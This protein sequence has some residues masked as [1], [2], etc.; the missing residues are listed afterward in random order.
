MGYAVSP[1]KVK[2][3]EGILRRIQEALEKG[4]SIA[5]G[6]GR[7]GLSATEYQLHAILKAAQMFKDL[8]FGDLRARVKVSLHPSGTHVIVSP[9]AMIKVRDV[10]AGTLETVLSNMREYKGELFSQEAQLQ[11]EQLAELKARA[12]ESGWNVYTI[13]MAKKGSYLV[14]AERIEMP[15]EAAPSIDDVDFSDLEEA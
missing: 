5:F 11:E 3:N 2:Q 6:A 4:E 9:K 12:E 10:A 14:S 1:E 8:G 15:E 13:P 7:D